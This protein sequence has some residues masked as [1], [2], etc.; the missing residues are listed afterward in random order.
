MNKRI[1]V[2]KISLFFLLAIFVTSCVTVCKR[3]NYQYSFSEMREIDSLIRE[4]VPK[5]TTDYFFVHRYIHRKFNNNYYYFLKCDDAIIVVQLNNNRIHFF[6][7][8]NKE[9]FSFTLEN[10]DKI[11]SDTLLTFPNKFSHD[12]YISLSGIHDGVSFYHGIHYRK[13]VKC[14]ITE[15]WLRLIE[16]DLLGIL[17]ADYPIVRLLGRR[18]KIR[19]KEILIILEGLCNSTY[20]IIR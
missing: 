7:K 5:V 6:K 17:E 11:I 1:L 2:F 13:I 12:P 20:P 19:S 18:N 3:Y 15:E 9:T 8:Y 10:V 14:S 16:R 4:N